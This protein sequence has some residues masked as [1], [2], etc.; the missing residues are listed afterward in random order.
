MR[1]LNGG[2]DAGSAQTTLRWL[3]T[4]EGVTKSENAGNAPEAL[5]KTRR[6][7]NTPPSRRTRPAG[8]PTSWGCPAP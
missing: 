2:A 5:S 6:V 7:S 8:S 4:E 1:I 3:Q